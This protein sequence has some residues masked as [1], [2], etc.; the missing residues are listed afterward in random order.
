MKREL[1]LLKSDVDIL[2]Y[3]FFSAIDLLLLISQLC[4]VPIIL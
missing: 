1:S 4:A 2:K 3:S